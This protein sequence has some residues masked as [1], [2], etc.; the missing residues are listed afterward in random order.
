MQILILIV[1]LI[2]LAALSSFITLVLN[3]YIIPNLHLDKPFTIHFLVVFFSLLFLYLFY[4]LYSSKETE[5]FAKFREK[6]YK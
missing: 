5:R 6:F 4:I 3:I 2:F 1:W